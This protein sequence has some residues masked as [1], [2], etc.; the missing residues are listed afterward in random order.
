MRHYSYA[1]ETRIEDATRVLT[2]YFKGSANENEDMRAEM[3]GVVESILGAASL[4]T[5]EEIARS[6][7]YRSGELMTARVAP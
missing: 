4:Y 3:R 5:E 2:H 6:A 1:V 7:Q